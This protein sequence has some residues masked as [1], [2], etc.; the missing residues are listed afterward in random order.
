MFHLILLL[1]NFICLEL[2]VQIYI[3]LCQ[4]IINNFSTKDYFGW[5]IL[6]IKRRGQNVKLEDDKY[7]KRYFVIIHKNHVIEKYYNI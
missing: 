3:E 5:T 2:F 7:S 4:W 1:T 6:S